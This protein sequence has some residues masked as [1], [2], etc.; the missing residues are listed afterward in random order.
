MKRM[1]A[2]LGVLAAFALACGDS[3][4][5]TSSGPEVQAPQ[6]PPP[7]PVVQVGDSNPNLN[8]RWNGKGLP[9]SDVQVLVS[10]ETMAL[11]L[12][13]TGDFGALGARWKEAFGKGGW[14]SEDTFTDTNFEA[15]I[16]SK[17]GAQLGWAIGADQ[18]AVLVYLEDLKLIPAEESTVKQA[19]TQTSGQRITRNTRPRRLTGTTPGGNTS[20]GGARSLDGGGRPAAGGGNQGGGNQGGG[21]GGNQGGGRSMER[22]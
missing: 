17:D 14:K 4:T 2:T 11:V 18:G 12:Y 7:P 10:D 5:P 15:V 6:P 1:I 21:R 13:E 19:R 20:A 22:R 3:D 9:V 16:W 8:A